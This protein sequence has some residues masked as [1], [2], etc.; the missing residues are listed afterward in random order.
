M[1]ELSK[2]EIKKIKKIV[3]AQV[4]ENIR[5]IREEKGLTQIELAHRIHS[6]RQYLYKIEKAKVGISISKLAVIARALDIPIS[7]LVELD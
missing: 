3:P 2:E 6:D 5:K 7:K 1:P 4:G